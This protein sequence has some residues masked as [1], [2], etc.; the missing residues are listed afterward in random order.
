MEEL[1]HLLLG[2]PNSTANLQLPDPEL[3]TYYRNFEDRVIW[4]DYGIDENILEVSR[5]I[6]YFNK[7]DKNIPIEERKPIKLLVYSRGGDGDACFSL[8]DV[9]ALS[10]TPV[11]TVNMG[12]SMSAGLLILLAGHKRFCLKTS[13][14]L[15][16]SGSGGTS[17]TYE[18]TEAAM[19]DY[20]RFVDTM[21]N[22]I[23]ERTNIDTK[24]LNRYKSKEWYL[25]ANDQVKYGIVEKIVDDIDE[26]L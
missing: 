24:T 12:V 20:K 7:L 17:G 15:A 23:I 9:I 5:L 19:K 21:R 26:I 10:K 13:T 3:L 8:L 6:M 4:I 1:Q 25:Y 2:I 16:H 22:Y 14:A 18:Q 11:W